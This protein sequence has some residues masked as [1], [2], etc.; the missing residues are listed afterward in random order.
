[1]KIQPGRCMVCGCTDHW[2]CAV[3]CWWVDA[4]HTLCS[5]CA[6]NMAVLALALRG[7]TESDAVLI[8]YGKDALGLDERALA[9]LLSQLRQYRETMRGKG[10]ATA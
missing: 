1:M 2:G 5:R 8:G 10:A 6:D 4:G 9:G 7:R 3:G